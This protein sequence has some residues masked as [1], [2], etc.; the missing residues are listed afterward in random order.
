MFTKNDLAEKVSDLDVVNFLLSEPL[1]KENPVDFYADDLTMHGEMMV[2]T[3]RIP[4]DYKSALDT[5]WEILKENS[6][7]WAG[8]TVMLRRIAKHGGMMLTKNKVLQEYKK[9]H[10]LKVRLTKTYGMITSPYYD[11]T[12]M[13]KVAIV[14]NALAMYNSRLLALFGRSLEKVNFR[15]YPRWHAVTSMYANCMNVSTY[16]M[17]KV[18]FGLSLSTAFQVDPDA[19][20][21][22]NVLLENLEAYKGSFYRYLGEYV[23]DYKAMRK[24]S[25]GT[26][27][28]GENLG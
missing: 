23:E 26:T 6:E 12:F 9:L 27:V 2:V 15:A 3:I 10:E 22:N 25:G 17:Y 18:A 14:D 13:K 11:R 8:V 28:R 1:D 4:V 20:V 19:D 5:I 21:I 16:A 7:Y 24:G